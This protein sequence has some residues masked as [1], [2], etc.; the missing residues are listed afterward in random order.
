MKIYKKSELKLTNGLLVT[1]K[2][3][4]VTVDERIVEQANDLETLLQKTEYLAAQPSASPMPSLAGFERKRF[5]DNGNLY[6][7]TVTPALD[8][9]AEEAMAIMGEIDNMTTAE[10]ANRMIDMFAD[11]I[12]FADSDTV[13]DCE[14]ECVDPFDMPTLGSILELT[15]EDI[16]GVIAFANGMAEKVEPEE[17]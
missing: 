6:F 1:K 5:D 15:H 7:S 12:R 11:L 9:K 4:V 17:E 10:Q 14:A 8:A 13:I 2:G 3:D 16:V